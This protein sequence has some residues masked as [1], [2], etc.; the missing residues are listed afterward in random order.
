MILRTGNS[1]RR[2][3]T[4][5]EILISVAILA[6]AVVLIMQALARGAYLMRLA[7]N[8]LLAY[9]FATAKMAD[10][11]TSLRQGEVPK[12]F[13]EF[14]NGLE[15]FDWRV[16]ADP[17]EDPRLERLTLTVEW[18]QGRDAYQSSVSLLRRLPVTAS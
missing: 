10:L 12:L 9:T 4:F 2:G 3:L 16:H 8:R 13:G 14:R 18:R 7:E 17:E 5:V 11:E 6:G 15:R 1:G